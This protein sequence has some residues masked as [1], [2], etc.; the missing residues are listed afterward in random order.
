MQIRKKI[1][2]NQPADKVWEVLGED[3]VN[4][5]EWMS[6]AFHSF[7]LEEK[8][9]IVAPASGRVCLIGDKKSHVVAEE[10]LVQFDRN[11]KSFILEVVPTAGKKIP[12]IKSMSKFEV[13]KID[14]NSCEVLCSPNVT[15]KPYAYLIYPLL[16]FGLGRDFYNLLEDLKYFMENGKVHPRKV[17]ATELNKKMKN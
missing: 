12:V 5:A 17:K 14:A 6:M 4:S 16:K 8:S 2:I 7:E 1:K 11:T 9:N 3:F 15:I 10:K 13:K